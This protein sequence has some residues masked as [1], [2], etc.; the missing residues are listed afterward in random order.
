MSRQQVRYGFLN[1]TEEMTSG[2]L[3]V[4]TDYSR[5]PRELELSPGESRS[6][7]IPLRLREAD[8]SE[9]RTGSLTLTHLGCAAYAFDNRTLKTHRVELETQRFLLQGGQVREINTV[10]TFEIAPALGWWVRIPAGDGAPGM[11]LVEAP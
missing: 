8:R 3:S 7:P 6:V 11:V 5:L 4:E 2:A 10:S 1:T 9:M